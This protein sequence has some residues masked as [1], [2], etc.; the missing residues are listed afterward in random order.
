MSEVEKNIKEILEENLTHIKH[1]HDKEG[2]RI[3]D[4]QVL[5]KAQIEFVTDKINKEISEL[6]SDYERRLADLGTD[7]V[8]LQQ[9]INCLEMDKKNVEA[10][11][12]RV[13][14][15][16]K[17]KDYMLKHWMPGD[18]CDGNIRSRLSQAVEV[19]EAAD[20]LIPW[21]MATH[22]HIPTGWKEFEEALN[23]YKASLTKT[24]GGQ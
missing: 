22:H 14:E 11:E 18:T 8:Q 24:D 20:K 13:E 12:K 1:Y 19:V 3:S 2:G 5:F 6:T 17:E 10:L 15:L 16:E 23:K 7:C 4:A 21:C 9:Y